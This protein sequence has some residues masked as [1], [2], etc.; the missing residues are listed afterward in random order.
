MDGFTGFT[1]GVL[2]D[3]SVVPGVPPCQL[4][5]GELADAELAVVRW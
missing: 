5:V 1:L 4:V 2:G 3:A